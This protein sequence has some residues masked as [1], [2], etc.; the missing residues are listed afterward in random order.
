M[1]ALGM[2]GGRSPELL[3]NTRSIT[4][5]LVTVEV[6]WFATITAD[7]QTGYEIHVFVD[8]SII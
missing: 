8:A 2:H 6:W 5:E 7:L 4:W 3:F 1:L